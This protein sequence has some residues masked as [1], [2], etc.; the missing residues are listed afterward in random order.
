M[1]VAPLRAR[2]RPPVVDGLFYPAKSEQL[3]GLVDQLRGSSSVP[4]GSCFAVVSPHAGYEYAG[5]VMAAAFRCAALRRPR[6]VILV[7]PVHRDPPGGFYL[8]ESESFSTPLG[9]VLVDERAAQAVL[10]SD[11]AF[12]R[13]DIFHLEEHCLE[14]QIPFVQREFPGAAVLPILTGSR[15]TAAAAALSAALRAA[16]EGEEQ[17]TV[18]IVSSNTASYMAGRDVAA[19]ST[20]LEDLVLRKDWRGVIGAEEKKRISACG[21]TGIAAVLSLTGGGCRVSIVERGGSRNDEQGTART[22]HYA[23]IA[24][25]NDARS[26]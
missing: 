25:D 15:G 24:F 8:P 16:R 21:A 4:L 1:G 13:N 9:E 6:T 11:P 26:D 7:G 5:S 20:L 12:Q 19:E 17:S 3:R 23:A 2:V 22:V 18:I 14:V 10:S